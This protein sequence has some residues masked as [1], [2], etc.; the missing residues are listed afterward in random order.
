MYF[1]YSIAVFLI[2]FALKFIA[3]FNA[4]IKLF[5][6]GRQHTF[7]RLQQHI[8]AND[9][10]IWI[11][12]A[13][14]GEFEQG[15]PIMEQLK[16]QYP[17]FKIL[18]SFFSP[19]GFEVQKDYPLV[20]VVVYLPLDMPFQV[21]RFLDL[22]H[23]EL[24]V[25]IKY[26][27]WP[28]LLR[29]LQQRSIKTLLVSAIFRKEQIFFKSYGTWMRQSLKGFTHFF[30]QNHSSKTLLS[31]IGFDHCTISGDTRFD[32]VAE[33][34]Q[35]NNTL[36]FIEDFI[37]QHYTVV[38]GSTW[39]KDEKVLV[40]YINFHASVIEK[41]IIAPH[42]INPKTIDQLEASIQ[43]PTTKYSDSNR[44][45]NAQVFIL[46]TIGVLTKVY[47]YAD[48]AYVGGGFGEDGVHN[49][50]EPATFGVPLIIGPIYDKFQEVKDL[51]ELKACTVVRNQ[52]QLNQALK[53][54]YTNIK[55]RQRQ[56]HIAKNYVTEHTGATQKV[57]DFIN[58]IL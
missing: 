56:G 55:A 29:A 1:L 57:I 33:I 49:V 8:N 20:D 42:N 43:K 41:F 28:N 52:E 25:F 11:H 30:V 31:S 16:Q 12:C 4:K 50:L 15:R 37:Q 48:T 18:L 7:E 44:N 9:R 21:N 54:S 27:F 58:K 10:V 23:P 39:P 40:N 53:Q 45:N 26:E 17:D 51:V 46:D 34:T 32:R 6:R 2:S 47:A 14:L 38:A 24:V 3:P 19:S 36:L 5:V 22:A 13:S 35:Q